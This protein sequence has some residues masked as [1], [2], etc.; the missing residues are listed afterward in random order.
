MKSVSFGKR[1]EQTMIDTYL[2]R[3]Y[4]SV[5]SHAAY[6]RKIPLRLDWRTVTFKM[7][8]DFAKL[9]DEDLFVVSSG[10]EAV[11]TFIHY[12]E[13]VKYDGYRLDIRKN[14]ISIAASNTRGVRY[15]ISALNG[16]VIREGKKF[17]FPIALIE[18]YPSFPFRGI[19][20]GYYWEPWSF[21][22]R[23]TLADFMDSLRLNT[24]MYAPKGDPYHR[25]K[26]HQLYPDDIFKQIIALINKLKEKEIN[27]VYCISPGYAENPDEGFRFLGDEDY[28]RLFVKLDQLIS[29]GVNKFGLLLDD[30]DYQ[31]SPKDK[32]VFERPGIAHAHLANRI[33]KYL[34]EKLVNHR[35][36]LCPTEYSQIGSTQ[37]RNDLK[38]LLDKDIYIFWTGDHVCAEAITE[39]D[40]KLTR[41]AYDHDIFI[42]DNF[43]VSDFTRG[44]REFIAPIKNRASNLGDYAVGYL[45]NPSN[46]YYISQVAITT[47]AH[48]AWNNA[49]YDPEKS[50]ELALEKV[51]K[52]FRRV[53][54]D[55]LMHNYPSVLSHGNI[56][57]EREL[58][59]KE[60]KDKINAYYRKVALSANELL[61]L[62][63]PIIKQLKPWLIRTIRE[64]DIV[65]KILADE[66]KPEELR[67]FL[68]D[69]KFPGSELLDFLIA[70]RGLLSEEEYRELITKRRGGRWYRVFED[71]R[72]PVK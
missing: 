16:L 46:N 25:V 20:E 52:D 1:K 65:K 18:D 29:I 23:M 67:D 33:N 71:K 59:E 14:E 10:P 55:F 4:Y 43:P 57:K 19:I 6:T 44:V 39:R 8:S 56:E 28:Q 62:D 17:L 27:F 45:I 54:R 3:N 40:I 61:K 53:G 37:Y 36:V 63:L 2:F 64:A 12:D 5:D 9:L 72:W 60:D 69:I 13:N 30:I 38:K 11:P 24:Y 41:D 21:Q 66:I 26:W 51:G 34:A 7:Y 48:Y 22:E 70:K 68:A 49:K 58:V 31:L 47:M 50:F 32:L 35:L 15:A 42:W